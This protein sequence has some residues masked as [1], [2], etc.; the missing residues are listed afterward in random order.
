MDRKKI[1]SRSVRDE[2]FLALKEQILFNDLKPND[3]LQI[4]RLA[5]EF[6]VSATPVREALVKLESEGLVTL[7]RNKGAKVSDISD[8]DIRNT[9]EMRRLLESYA[10]RVSVSLITEN[11]LDDLE[12][13]ILSLKDVSFDEELYI[14]T[15]KRL[16]ELFFVHITNDLLKDSIRRVHE[17]SH[18]IRYIAEGSVLMHE[19]VVQDVMQEHLAIIVNIRS[20]NAELLV[21]LLYKHLLNGEKRTLE[22][23]HQVRDKEIKS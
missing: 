21:P 15:D 2:M 18:R 4:E 5:E 1:V 20:R 6:G 12:K 14:N 22:A 7:I 19:K 3:V 23:R 9:W 10:A 13:D 16:H 17:I 11:E 8:E